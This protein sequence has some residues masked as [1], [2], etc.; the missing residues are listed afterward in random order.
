[1]GYTGKYTCPVAECGFAVEVVADR[2]DSQGN[3]N[4]APQLVVGSAESG[5]FSLVTHGFE[6]HGVDW[7]AVGNETFVAERAVP[8]GPTIE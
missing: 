3:P 6:T 7:N 1:M 5:R 2:Y 8:A 4:I